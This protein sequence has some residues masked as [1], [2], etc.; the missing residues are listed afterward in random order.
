MQGAPIPQ[1][2]AM[3]GPPRLLPTA[4][5]GTYLPLHPFLRGVQ[6]TPPCLA[7]SPPGLQKMKL[8][9]QP[10]TAPEKCACKYFTKNLLIFATKNVVFMLFIRVHFLEQYRQDWSRRG[11]QN[12]DFVSNLTWPT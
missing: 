4:G 12:F 6:Q 9:L 11:D 10:Q 3:R 2:P 7:G 1:D 5:E 8:C